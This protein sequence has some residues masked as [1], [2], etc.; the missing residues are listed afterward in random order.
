MKSANKIGRFY[1]SSVIGFKLLQELPWGHW[2]HKD[3][4][5]KSTSPVCSTPAAVTS[6]YG[7]SENYVN[8]RQLL[9]QLVHAFIISRLD[10]CNYILTGLPKCL[11]LQLQQVQNAAARLIF[12]LRPRDPVKPA[13]QLHWLPVYYWVQYSLCLL[14]YSASHQCCP[15]YTSNKVQS[16]VTSTHCHGLWSSTCITYVVPRTPTTLG[17]R[18]SILSF[19]TCGMECIANQHPQHCSHKTI[20]KLVKDLFF[21]VAFTITA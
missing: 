3:M 21:N 16:V 4:S 8:H 6:N 5:D 2:C 17:E 13:L 7:I 20:W 18:V 11:I 12:E 19:R 10:Y 15:A 1:R 9:K 14:R